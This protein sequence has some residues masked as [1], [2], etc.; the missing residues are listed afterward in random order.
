MIANVKAF[1][2]LHF[3]I[4]LV[5]LSFLLYYEVER[6]T[7]SKY[8]PKNSPTEQYDTT[9]TQPHTKRELAHTE[10]RPWDEVGKILGLLPL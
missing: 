7:G 1:V 6:E 4:V 3:G 9:L 10:R 2:R 8:H 5:T